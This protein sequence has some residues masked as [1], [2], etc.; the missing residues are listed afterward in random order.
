MEGLDKDASRQTVLASVVGV[1][2]VLENGIL[3]KGAVKL[4]HPEKGN[5]DDDDDDEEDNGV[6]FSSAMASLTCR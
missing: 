3:S 6:T 2:F 5:G 4:F 1:A